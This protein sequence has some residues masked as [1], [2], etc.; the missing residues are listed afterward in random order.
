MDSHIDILE[1][2]D[3]LGKPFAG[4][5]VLHLSLVAFFAAYFM[6]GSRA[7]DV[8]GSKMIGNFVVATFLAPR[9]RRAR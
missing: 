2:S 4:S 7:R 6:I 1:Q 5:I 3:S 9:R 8:W